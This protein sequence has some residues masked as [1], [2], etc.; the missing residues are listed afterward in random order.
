MSSVE[1]HTLLQP[2]PP[3]VQQIVPGES[4]LATTRFRAGYT[5]AECAAGQSAGADRNSF[6]VLEQ[7]IARWC[8]L[9]PKHYVLVPG[10]DQTD[11]RL[12][13]EPEVLTAV[14]QVLIPSIEGHESTVIAHLRPTTIRSSYWAVP[15][16]ALLPIKSWMASISTSMSKGLVIKN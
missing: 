12:A 16:G 4:S 9:G 14:R 6:A 15:G 10:A 7:S 1:G 5:V 11:P 2:H 3:P 8:T 13:S